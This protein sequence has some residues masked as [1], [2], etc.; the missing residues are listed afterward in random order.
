[1]TRSLRR[2]KSPAMWLGVALVL[3]CSNE[4]TAPRAVATVTV[5]PTSPTLVVGGSVQLTAI[6][7]DDAGNPVTGRTV[8]W[9]T[10]DAGMATVSPTG[11][12]TG[13]AEGPVTVTA[14]SE[15]KSGA[16]DVT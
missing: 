15:S 9:T 4:P 2:G 14:T 3:D 6:T 13:I 10:S 7:T 5:G 12:V 16:A 8:T 1:M 11:L